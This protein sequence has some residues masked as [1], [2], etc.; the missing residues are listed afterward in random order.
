MR[1]IWTTED[2]EWTLTSG[3]SSGGASRCWI[4]HN[5]CKADNKLDGYRHYVTPNGKSV[6]WIASKVGSCKCKEEPPEGMTT[7][8]LLSWLG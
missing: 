6:G 7:Q 4:F 5:V 8:M 1:E 3:V 2:K